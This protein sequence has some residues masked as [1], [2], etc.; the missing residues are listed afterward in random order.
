MADWWNFQIIPGQFSPNIHN[1][2]WV[3]RFCTTLCLFATTKQNRKNLFPNAW[4]ALR[5]NERQTR[6][7]PCGFWKSSIERI[8]QKI[9]RCEHFMLLLS[10]DTI[11]DKFLIA[12]SMLLNAFSNCVI[13][14]HHSVFFCTLPI[15]VQR[16]FS[17]RTIL[18]VLTVCLLSFCRASIMFN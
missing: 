16:K 5:R 2:H 15:L 18:C 11:V 10:L 7:H 6:S 1:P 3:K 17:M 14:L 9:S 12:I 4:I 8:Q 13:R